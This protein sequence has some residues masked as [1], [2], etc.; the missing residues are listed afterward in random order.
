MI[1]GR[2]FVI[3]GLQSWDISIGSNA[4][5]IALEFSKNNR[6]LY[7]NTPLDKK[8]YQSTENTPDTIQR[9]NVIKKQSPTLRQINR[10]LW[11]LDYP[12]A[13]LPVNFLPDGLFFDLF[14]RINN[15]KMYS[16]VNK[17]LTQLQFEN[18]ILFIDNDIYRSFYAKEYLKPSLSIYYRRD[19]LTP[20]PFWR[21]HILRLEPLL[22]RKSDLVVCN[23]EQ[24]AQYG[25]IFN[26]CTYDVGQGVDLSSFTTH[27]TFAIPIDTQNIKHP[28]I[29]Y[30]GDINSQRLDVTLIYEL[31]SNNPDMSFVLV[32]R[33]DPVFSSHQLNKLSNVHFLG[34][35]PMSQVPEYIQ[36]FDICLNPQLVNEITI[37]NY[38]RK[39]DE[40]LA[41]GKPVI[42]TS[43][44]TMQLF[45]D[46]VYLCNSLKD[47]QQSIEAA[48]SQ[49]SEQ[50]IK[51]R[52]QFAHTHTWNNSVAKI[53]QYINTL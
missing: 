10:N 2:D 51:Q 23:S 6:V 40:F 8:T 49:K 53:Y 14:N 20:I 43:T 44:Q 30:C 4:K 46:Y 1:T 18:F 39:I 27:T 32:G 19:N 9:R 17:I 13:I 52:I 5:D 42:A 15:Y 31:A 34:L 21:K 48:L 26:K 38:P 33:C 12:F 22:I 29:G 25:R 16:Y 36:S 3:T 7:I 45:K 50:I 47:Y 28:I 35:K 11:V 24:L 41:L 37:G